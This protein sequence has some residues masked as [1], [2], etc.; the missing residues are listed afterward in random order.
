MGYGVWL[1]YIKLNKVTLNTRVFLITMKYRNPLIHYNNGYRELR[2]CWIIQLLPNYSITPK[3]WGPTYIFIAANFDYT[4]ISS[5]TVIHISYHYLCDKSQ[6]N[7]A[8]CI[9]PGIHLNQLIYSSTEIISIG[10][11]I[12]EL[13]AKTSICS[14]L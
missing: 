7:S 11:M 14:L 5:I 9:S 1:W 2:C 3:K 6:S 13:F 8:P 12:I 10:Y 4:Y